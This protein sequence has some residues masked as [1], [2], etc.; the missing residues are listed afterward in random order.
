MINKR[1]NVFETNSSS[2]HTVTIN[3]G[4]VNDLEVQSDGY[5]HVSLNYYGKEFDWYNNSYD[6]LC[7]AILTVCYTKGI[8]LDWCDR[9]EELDEQAYEEEYNYWKDCLQDLLDT[10]EYKL[11]EECVVTEINRQ[12][13]I[14]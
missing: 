12:N 14:C 9:Y 1:S 2:V 7:Y 4:N 8:Y 11:I 6:K 13:R 3:T 10:E 5:V